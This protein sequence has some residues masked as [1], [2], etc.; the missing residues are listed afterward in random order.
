MKVGFLCQILS[1][2]CQR[3]LASVKQFTVNCFISDPHLGLFLTRVYFL[4]KFISYQSL[5]LTQVYFLPK[6]ISYPS[7]CLAQILNYVVLNRFDCL[8]F[9]AT[10]YSSDIR[11]GKNL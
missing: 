9:F 2:N 10:E 5:F 3:A 11:V 6:F 1:C 8:F 4:P 7:L